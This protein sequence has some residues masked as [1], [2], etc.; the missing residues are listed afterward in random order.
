MQSGWISRWRCRLLFAGCLLAFAR[1]VTAMDLQLN[2]QER[3][4]LLQEAEQ[5]YAKGLQLQNDSAIESQ[6]AF[7]KAADRY[8]VLARH[9]PPSG[10]LYFNL[11]NA[12][13][14]AG[15]LGGA[16]ANYLRAQRLMPGDPLVASNLARARALSRSDQSASIPMVGSWW[17]QLVAWQNVIPFSR[18]FWMALV[19][20]ELLWLALACMLIIRRVPWRYVLVPIAAVWLVS[21]GSM[22]LTLSQMDQQWRGVVTGSGVALRSG[23]GESFAPIFDQPLNPGTELIV[24][25]RRG[26]WVRVKSGSGSDANGAGWIRQDELELVAPLIEFWS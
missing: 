16:I 19:C 9:S 5:A 21:V 12:Q 17:D 7:E 13:L 22:C 26:R 25:E 24:L 20:W 2:D 15:R 4:A 14:Q 1:P 23:D 18:R 10:R 11:A 8:Q 6:Q 3:A